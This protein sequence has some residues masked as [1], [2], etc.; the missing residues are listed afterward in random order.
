ME[1]AELGVASCGQLLTDSGRR[2]WRGWLG[3]PLRRIHRTKDPGTTTLNK[4]QYHSCWLEA[5]FLRPARPWSVFCADQG[6]AAFIG[7]THY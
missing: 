5:V 3:A 2:E 4:I 6:D 7:Y 1:S